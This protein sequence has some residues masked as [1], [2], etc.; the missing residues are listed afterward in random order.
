MALF[1]I[2]ELQALVPFRQ[3]QGGVDLYEREIEDLLWEN[4]EEFAGTPLFRVAR[5]HQIPGGGRP[6]VIALDE[7]ARIVV[8]E[9]KRDV[10][11]GQ[12]AQCLE[13]AGWAQ[14][15]SLDE[16]SA[17]YHRGQAVFF[18]EWQDFT[19]SSAP[20][21]INPQ[22][23][24]MLVARDFDERTQD[25]L[26]YL[27]ENDLPVSV[28][29]V[30]VY[31]DETE[32]RFVDIEGE[33]D[34]DLS[35]AGHGRTSD[36]KGS[37][38]LLHGRRVRISDLLDEGS[39]QVGDELVWEQPRLG[40]THTARIAENG[41]ITLADGRSFSTPSTAAMHAADIAACDGWNAWRRRVDGALLHDLR[42][43]LIAS[44]NDEGTA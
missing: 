19:E 9:I 11:R 34:A 30:V 39:L 44:S 33:R 24:L 4:V 16:L 31:Q 22:P 5:Q 20:V 25:A 32:R 14:D 42:V 6:D 12:L 27:L 28:V 21:V 8:V 1:E 23:R 15:S 36:R 10:D 26:E 17:M 29:R 2:G 40:K 18:Q 38:L 3:L 37:E 35:V 41:A 43:K 13:Y 7:S